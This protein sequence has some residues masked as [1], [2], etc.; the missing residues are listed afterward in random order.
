MFWRNDRW[1]TT[2]VECWSSVLGNWV[3]SVEEIRCHELGILLNILLVYK[4]IPKSKRVFIAKIRRPVSGCWR[5]KVL[6]KGNDRKGR[7]SDPFKF[8][9]WCRNG[10]QGCHHWQIRQFTLMEVTVRN[11]ILVFCDCYP[12]ISFFL[13]FGPRLRQTRIFRIKPS[14]TAFLFCFCFTFP[15]LRAFRVSAFFKS[16]SIFKNLQ[17]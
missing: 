16:T 4:G 15:V 1:T 12:E 2:L 3:C 6:C 10:P 9:Q 13:K 17:Q 5:S 11:R 14:N 8:N 7:N